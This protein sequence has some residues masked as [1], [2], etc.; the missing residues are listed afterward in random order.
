MIEPSV[1]PHHVTMSQNVN[2][3]AS[4]IYG[5]NFIIY[6][7]RQ[8]LSIERRFMKMSIDAHWCWADVGSRICSVLSSNIPLPGS[9]LTQLM[10][11]YDVTRGQC[12]K[13][14]RTIFYT[15]GIIRGA[16]GGAGLQSPTSQHGGHQN[17][18]NKARPGLV[19][20][21]SHTLT[22]AYT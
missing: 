21:N 3:L 17:K 1:T 20:Y 5:F 10:M 14:S 9:I 7:F 16:N 22:Q 4:G 19:F 6:N 11:S 13:H 18:A 8:N 2:L 12:V 15:Y